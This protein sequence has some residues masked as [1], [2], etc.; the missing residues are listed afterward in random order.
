MVPRQ[1]QLVNGNLFKATLLGAAASLSALAPAALAQVEGEDATSIQET[2]IVIAPEYVAEDGGTANKANIPLIQTP[3]SVSVITRDQIDLLA[4]IDAQQAVRYTAGAFGENY[5]PDLRFDFVTV[6]GFTPKQYIDGLAAPVSTSIQSVGL[7]LY[8]FES[9]DVL[10]GPASALYGSSPPGGLYNQISRRPSDEFGGEV[11]AKFGTED[12]KQIA[13]TV[14]GPLSDSL[15]YSLTGLYLDREAERDDVSA[16]RLLVA[17]AVT[18]EITPATKLTGLGYFQSDE[19]RG[20][21]NGFLPVYGTLL[22]NPLGKVDPSTNLG[23]PNNLFERDQWGA[24]YEFS[25]AFS[26]T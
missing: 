23:D 7:D 24:G 20:D 14:H 3:Q 6:R 10:K 22:P 16:E 19:V 18:W 21:T 5:G 9:F 25:H 17:P 15:S 26:R 11:Q 8:A 4:F 1:R 2:I 13:G 12:Y